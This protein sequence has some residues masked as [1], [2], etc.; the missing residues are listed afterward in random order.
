M[1]FVK[2]VSEKIS[3]TDSLSSF[4]PFRFIN[5]TKNAW[6]E[7]HS[8][9]KVKGK[10]DL[11]AMDYSDGNDEPDSRAAREEMKEQRKKVCLLIPFKH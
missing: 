3:N 2:R 1:K 7:R 10:Y 4:F 11:L 5:K 9:E 8:F 6:H